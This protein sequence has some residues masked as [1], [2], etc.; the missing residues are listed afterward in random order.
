MLRDHNILK[1]VTF[2]IIRTITEL[3]DRSI[4][5]SNLSIN[6]LRTSHLTTEWYGAVNKSIRGDCID[7]DA[8]SMASLRPR[9][10]RVH[11]SS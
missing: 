8:R 4:S 1:K 5:K 7:S 2:R 6:V 3:T 9:R 10:G 11:A